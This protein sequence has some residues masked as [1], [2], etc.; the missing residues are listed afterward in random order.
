MIHLA[1]TSPA[2]SLRRPYGQLLGYIAA[3]IMIVFVLIHLIRIDTFIPEISYALPV[4]Q[5]T[6]SFLAL[7]II[8]SEIF[9]VPFLLRM[10]LSPLARFC[11]GLLVILAPL[12]W[13]LVAVW[14]YGVPVS[15]AQLGE[16]YSLPS[17]AVLIGFNV[18]WLALNYVTI[19]AL[20]FDKP[21]NWR[22][23]R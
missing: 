6:A 18:L 4:S 11:S 1:H 23:T 16:F 3:A 22:K 10:P 9:A 2:P 21:V 14:N 12:S 15:T 20:G 17:G 19:W 8:T 7:L 5:N 13:L